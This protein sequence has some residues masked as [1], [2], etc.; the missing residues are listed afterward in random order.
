[1]ISFY[2]SQ[3]DMRIK[4]NLIFAA[5]EAGFKCCCFG[6]KL[7]KTCTNKLQASN[8]ITDT[9]CIVNKSKLNIG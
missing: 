4:K 8:D 3:Q 2:D 5:I 9:E 1:M 7:L 6:K